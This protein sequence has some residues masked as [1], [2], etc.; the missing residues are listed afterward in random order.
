MYAVNKHM[1]REYNKHEIRVSFIEHYIQYDMSGIQAPVTFHIR[2]WPMIKQYHRC[3]ELGIPFVMNDG[4]AKR[5]GRPRK[6]EPV[7]IHRR[8]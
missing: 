7:F 4:D 1:A 3:K 5:I 6:K 2:L 8:P